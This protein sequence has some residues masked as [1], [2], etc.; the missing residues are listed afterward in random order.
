MRQPTLIDGRHSIGY[1]RLT[2]GT[3]DVYREPDR[4]DGGRRAKA[5]VPRGGTGGS[6]SKGQDRAASAGVGGFQG[7]A[8]SAAA[9]AASWSRSSATLRAGGTTAAGSSVRRVRGEAL[10]C[11]RVR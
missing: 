9:R 10:L 2:D 11:L 3:S 5:G 1:A 6:G 7:S 4:P 8:G